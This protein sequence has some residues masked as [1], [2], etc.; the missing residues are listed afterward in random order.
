[1]FFQVILESLTIFGINALLSS[2]LFLLL[3]PYIRDRVEEWIQDTIS[4]YIREQ[5]TLTLQHPEETAKTFAPL[6][7]AIIKEIMKDFQSSQKESTIKIPFLG[8]VPASI[9]QAL[10]ERFLGG[11]SKNNEVSNPFA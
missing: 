9:A 4:G 5:L 6:I 11:S 8:K 7:N 2:L 1:M 3:R 10:I